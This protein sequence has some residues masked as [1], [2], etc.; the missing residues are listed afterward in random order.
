MKELV[1]LSRQAGVKPDWIQAG[2][3]NTSVK[4]NGLMHIK[5]SGTLLSDMQSNQGIAK[6][7]LEDIENAFVT[8]QVEKSRGRN[9]QDLDVL[10]QNLL[11]GA[12][13]EQSPRPSIETWLHALMG[14]VTLHTHPLLACVLLVQKNWRDLVSRLGFDSLCIDYQTPGIDLALTLRDALR[15]ELGSHKMVFLQN[16]GVI[17]SAGTVEETLRQAQELDRRILALEGFSSD[18]KLV[19]L[20]PVF[21]TVDQ[22]ERIGGWLKTLVGTDFC[23]VNNSD[24]VVASVLHSHPRVCDARPFCPDV[25]VY[26]GPA[27]CRADSL[28]DVQSFVTRYG[29]PPRVIVTQEGIYFAGP[30][31]RKVRETQELFR[32]FCQVQAMNIELGSGEMVEGL[33]SEEIGWLCNWEAE[34][35]RQ[36]IGVK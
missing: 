17:F 2:G 21:P 4:E 35:Y 34:K 25:V 11:T 13:C 23:V 6:V 31:L 28:G 32:F 18:K 9:R 33:S 14:R 26:C 12:T 20:M 10:A 3:G 16:H 8:L 30:N 5:A 27:I 7:R 1:D 22:S 29:L 36:S 15:G 19:S 24:F